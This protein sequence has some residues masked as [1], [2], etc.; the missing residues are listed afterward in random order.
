MRQASEK[1][2]SLPSRVMKT[3]HSE[4]LAVHGIMGLVQQRAAGWGR[5]LDLDVMV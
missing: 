4:E 1:R 3:F 2:R 5:I